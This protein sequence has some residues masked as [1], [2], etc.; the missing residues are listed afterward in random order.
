MS[1]YTFENVLIVGL[2]VVMMLIMI[3]LVYFVRKDSREL[4]EALRKYDKESV[5][6]GGRKKL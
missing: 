3:H 6:R 4:Q 2:F 1:L 5:E